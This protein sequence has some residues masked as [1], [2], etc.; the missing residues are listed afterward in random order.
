MSEG[1]SLQ[2]SRGTR[3][4]LLWATN[5]AL[6]MLS[7]SNVN[8]RGYIQVENGTE[9]VLKKKKATETNLKGLHIKAKLAG[10]EKLF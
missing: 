3:G 10:R 1:A 9:Y 2:N 8:P 7:A 5:Y 6:I 4:S